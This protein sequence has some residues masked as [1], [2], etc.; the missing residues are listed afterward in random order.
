MKTNLRFITVIILFL[1]THFA[2]SQNRVI[3]GTVMDE[4]KSPLPGVSIMIEGTTN[5]TITDV[6]GKYSI[7]V[8]SGKII[9]QFSFV[10]FNNEIVDVTNQNKVNIQ[11]KPSM[12]GLDEVVAV[13]Y[14]SMRKS[15]LTG[16]VTSVK[17]D[18]YAAQ[19]N[20]TV[21]QLLQGRAAGVQVTQNA[22]SPGSGVSVRIRGAS[23]LRGNNEPLYVVD[24][25][26]ISSA[27]E[28]VDNATTTS[29]SEVQNGLNGINPRD[30]EN[31]EIL[32][33]A[34]ATAIY[35][36][37]GANGVVLITTKKGN[38]AKPVVNSYLNVS[39]SQISKKL[40][41]LDGIEFAKYQNES[42]TLSG[43]TQVPYAI[44]DGKVYRMSYPNGVATQGSVAAELINWQDEIFERGVSEDAGLSISGKTDK[45]NY[46]VSVGYKSTNGIVPNTGVKS[47][48]FAI[49][50]NQDLSDKFKLETKFS[51]F[52]GT[53][54]FAQ[55]GDKSAGPNSFVNQLIKYRPLINFGD[56]QL[57]DDLEVSN[58]YTWVDDYKDKS[59]ESR[60]MGSFALTYKFPIKG[61]SYKIQ[62][63]GDMRMK[64]RRR[65]FGLTT[66]DGSQ[67][68]GLLSIS[69]MEAK[70]YQINNLLNFNRVYNK[71]HSVNFV[72]GTTYDVKN[73]EN[74]VY[75]VKNFS[76][77]VFNVKSPKYGQVVSIPLDYRYS[78]TELLSF[79][80][81]MG[82][83]FNNKYS[84]TGTFRADGSS[85]FAEGN[86]FSYF[87]SFAFAWRVKNESFMKNVD[88][89]SNLKVRTGWGQTGNQGIAPYQ[90][91]ANYGSTLYGNPSNSTVTAFIPLNILNNKLKWE[92]TT[93]L[94]LGVDFGLLDNRVNGSIDVYNKQTDDLL[95]LEVLPT[96]SGFNSLLI[97]RGSL[98]NKGLEAS[99]NAVVLKK[100]DLSIEVGGNISFNKSEIQ[101]LGIPASDIYMDGK[102]QQRSY[103]LGENVTN[104]AYF[105]CP[106]NVFI[107]GEEIGLFYGYETDGIYQ[108][109][110][111]IKITGAQPGD[112][113]IVDQNEDGVID[114]N[115]RTI[116]GNPNP[117]FVYGGFVS[118]NYKRLS[119]NV[120]MNGVSGNEIANGNLIQLA[121]PEGISS[122]T[123]ILSSTYKN[124]WRTDAPS[125]TIPRLNYANENQALAITDRIIED[126]SYFRISNITLSYDLP[127]GNQ[128]MFSKANV[129]VTG[130]NLL[131]ITGYS[132]FNPEITSFMGNANIM[133][134]DMV[135][136][137]NASSLTVGLNLTF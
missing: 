80:T 19:Q 3:T 118:V 128:K 48:N 132:G 58:P 89:I 10:G 134:V 101:K 119:L 97:N 2:W 59:K 92:T 25:I 53:G 51:S 91:F 14:G 67:N 104:A 7:S 106:G 41:V 136:L 23:S 47:G 29:R 18:S 81:R 85:K 110:D 90:T 56:N 9:L 68:N 8:P 98:N 88:A 71:K 45:S 116:I 38:S 61:L 44:Q 77:T 40:D 6:D 36:S 4:N 121:T 62:A 96:S 123:N 31:I 5:G 99:L 26:I 87:P 133:G 54:D 13:G 32:K 60:F 137:P 22:G 21:D 12:V 103:Y 107:D 76:T 78:D 127:L 108:T 16:S 43:N 100:G 120:Q 84:F 65:F 39:V 114:S 64:E 95:Q 86:K 20:A 42:Y 34:S 73:V 109:G 37:R 17:V 94:N 24:G 1:V 35:G 79:F 129:F 11:M 66:W 33:D 131:T 83:T 122:Y 57:D 105:K 74:L 28:D 115:D 52:Y 111:D 126:G 27:G 117:D 46:Y 102:L 15:D 49:K 130:S 125:N 82:Y 93:Q 72:A 55:G 113:K 30:I 75:E 63:A 112:V 50:F 124:A 69:D 135:G 70:S